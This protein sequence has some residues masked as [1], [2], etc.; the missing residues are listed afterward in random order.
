MSGAVDYYRTLMNMYSGKRK[1]PYPAMGLVEAGRAMIGAYQ[2][3][4][5]RVRPR[6]L[7][8]ETPPMRP[9]PAPS[10]PPP[11]RPVGVVV[12]LRTRRRR[13]TLTKKR[14]K[15]KLKKLCGFMQ[16]QE[17]THIH[18]DFV[19]TSLNAAINTAATQV[20]DNGGSIARHRFATK[21]LRFFDPTANPATG[22]T[23][24][25]VDIN[26]GENKNVYNDV[27]MSIYR[28]I[29]LKNNFRVP[30]QIELFKCYPK[31]ATTLTALTC[32]NNG[33][34]S[35][36]YTTPTP[37]DNTAS[38]TS[39]FV[40]INDSRDLK[41]VWRIEGC[42]NKILQ[43]G[44]IWTATDFCKQFNFEVSATGDHSFNYNK[45]Q[46]G[47]NWL[48]RVKGVISHLSATGAGQTLGQC[49]VDIALHAT[50]DI[51]Y[52]AGKDYHDITVYNP[53]P[54]TGTDLVVS[55]KPIARNQT[56]G[57]GL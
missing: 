22:S 30:V 48:L 53:N 37:T 54:T 17:A 32:F 47:F 40:F 43:P 49:G 14:L 5:R 7:A 36:T 13:R 50:Y 35:Q 8:P 6:I 19:C 55:Q 21:N 20:F 51:R 26:D 1:Y 16:Q 11:R 44:Q 18:R 28:K 57:V 42:G 31:D 27:R 52:D 46:G 45:N 9:R 23:A 34:A 4:Q 2:R 25:I 29:V 38:A 10:R 56:Y 12:P 24:K 33:I 15:K 41:F 39:P 3:S